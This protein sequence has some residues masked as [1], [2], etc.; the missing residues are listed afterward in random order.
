MDRI[1]K[2]ALI[3]PSEDAFPET[4][5]QQHINL[6]NG[7]IYYMYGKPLPSC[8]DNG[9]KLIPDSFIKR[10]CLKIYGKTILPGLNERERSIYRYLSNKNINVVLA[11]YGHTG[12]NIIDVC[13]KLGLPLI[14]HFFGH[15]AYR[16]KLLEANKIK[17][18]EMFEYAQ[19]IIT[20][21]RDMTN[22][23]V[24]LG[25]PEEKIVLSPCGPRQEFYELSSNFKEKRFLAIGRFVE[26]KAPYLSLD[27]FRKVLSECPDAVLYMIGDGPLLDVCKNLVKSWDIEKSVFFLGVLSPQEYKKIIVKSLAFIQHSI[28]ASD[29]DSE[30]TPV[31]I[32]EAG[33]AGLPVISTRHAGIQDV[34]VDGETGYLVDELDTDAMSDRMIKLASNPK[35]AAD[36]GSTAR[37]R[38]YNN[39]NLNSH[40]S[41]INEIVDNAVNPKSETS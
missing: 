7:E 6:L 34:V 23:L 19:A 24:M 11:E 3:S 41:K 9:I 20:V 30:G 2:L 26:K 39:Y 32:L 16:Q 37:N 8:V 29:G 13:T 35:L 14:V 33:A 21:S 17:Y 31:S 40:I 15:D 38:I 1:I 10:Y 12:A 28:V 4:F 18:T 27:A 25:C 36:L 5:I 22:Q